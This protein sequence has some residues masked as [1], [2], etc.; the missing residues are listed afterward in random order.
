MSHVADS[1]KP[2]FRAHFRAFYP[3]PATNHRCERNG[4]PNSWH[5]GNV[6]GPHR[7]PGHCSPLSHAP[8]ST[9]DQRGK[10]CTEPPPRLRL[11]PTGQLPKTERARSR[12]AGRLF[13][14]VT[15][16]GDFADKIS[17]FLLTRCRPTVK[18][19]RG[20]RR[21]TPAAQGVPAG[22]HQ[23]QC[24]FSPISPSSPKQLGMVS[25]ELHQLGLSRCRRDSA[26][27]L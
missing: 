11:P 16:P 14:Y 24:Q 22:G 17:P 21:S 3:H 19:S 8:R 6:G 13:E 5:P 10:S 2:P 20:R 7:P 18:H 26:I 4:L 23:P 12:R 9:P 15:E 1:P 27:R 25:P